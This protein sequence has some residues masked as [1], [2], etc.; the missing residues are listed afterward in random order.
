MSFKM[1]GAALLMVV[2]VPAASQSVDAKK[3]EVPVY[4]GQRARPNFAGDGEKYLRFKTAITNG[5]RS[6][7][8]AMGH[9]TI[10]TVG[11][12]TSCTFSWVGDVRTGKII[13][14]PLGGEDYPE[15]QI[16]TRPNN[17]LI[18]TLWGSYSGE[19]CTG[20]LYAFDGDKFVPA[21]AERKSPNSCSDLIA[22]KRF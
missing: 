11:C 2:A 22:A 3:Y 5:F 7:P 6:N 10:I 14:F 21:S 19:S 20:R 12:G 9:Y 18:L 17:R 4:S 15:L 16:L 1:I 8:I 13:T